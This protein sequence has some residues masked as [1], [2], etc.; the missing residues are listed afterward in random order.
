MC[1]IIGLYGCKGAPADVNCLA[2]AARTLRHRGPDDEGYLLVDS[3]HGRCELRSGADTIPELTHPRIEQPADFTPDLILGHRRLSIIDLSPGGHEPLTNVE[4][5]L[6]LTFNGE[7]YNYLEIR[8]ELKALGHVFH[9]EGDGEVIL[10]AYAQW[11]VE[12]LSRFIGMFSFALWDVKRRRL[13]CARDFLGIKPFYYVVTPDHIGF[14]SE[15]KALKVLFP[16]ACRPNLPYLYWYLQT[17]GVYNA[18]DTFFANVRELPGAHYL[19]VEDGVV[20]EP[21]RYWDVD[22]DRARA[23]YDYTNPEAEFLRLMR[24]SVRL[25]LR[26]DVPVGTCL[27]GGLDSS[28]IVALATEQ[29]NGGRMNSFSSIYASKGYDERRYIDLVASTYN[30]IR[31]QTTPQPE[32]FYAELTD[33][34]WHQDI[35]PAATGVYSQRFVMSL[36]QGNVT[37]LLDGQGADEMFAGYRRHVT[38]HIFALWR[39]DLARGLREGAQ[40]AWEVRERFLPAFNLREFAAYV[41]DY[42]SGRQPWLSPEIGAQADAYGRGV[43]RRELRGAD[44]LNR[45]LYRAVVQESIPSLLHYEDR[46]SMTYGIEARVPFLDHRLVEFALGVHGDQ[47]VRGAEGKGVMRRALRGILPDAIVE[48]R[49]K[50][51]YPT[52]YSA[53]TRDALAAE[54]EAILRDKVLKRGWYNAAQI[55]ALWRQH[56]AAQRDAGGVLFRLIATEMWLERCAT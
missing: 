45:L 55:E 32:G 53:W 50:L 4:R 52:P 5:D 12:C 39:R 49:D 14:A 23:A 28:A 25:Q 7:I 44:A 37:V 6:W 35:P 54:T 1:G 20:G 11:G 2:E 29:L 18:P 56:R 48:R 15:V 10:Q 42:L 19:L 16:E 47:K 17:G 43:S 21:V 33:I 22:L 3:Q 46:N 30:T 9:T 8:A 41:V 31:H 26:S 13:W 40:F 24:D 51:G 38:Q 34:I 36:A 27:S